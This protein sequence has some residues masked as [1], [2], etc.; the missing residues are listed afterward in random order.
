MPRRCLS[1]AFVI[2]ILVASAASPSA[3]S[4]EVAPDRSGVEV[5]IDISMMTGAVK[6]S[7]CSSTCRARAVRRQ[8]TFVSFRTG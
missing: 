1:Y 5:G 6:D 4:A 8:P 2:V 3:M 7:A